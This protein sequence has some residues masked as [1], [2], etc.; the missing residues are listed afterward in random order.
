M[1]SKMHDQFPAGST[2]ERQSPAV[3]PRSVKVSD[4]ADALNPEAA[5]RPYHHGQLR[6]SALL[7]ARQVV[8]QQG[9][10]A[11]SMRELAQQLGVAPSALYRHFADRTA[12]LLE[13]ADQVHAEHLVQLQV[14]QATA[15]DAWTALEDAGR[16]FLRFAQAQ[17]RMFRMMYDDAVIN[18]PRTEA[19]SPS[20]ELT[21]GLL[22][23]LAAQ[24]W[25][26]L[27]PQALRQRL[28]AYWSALFGCAT[29]GSHSLLKP[30]MLIGL[31]PAAVEDAVLAMAMGPRVARG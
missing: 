1:P 2:P 18:A 20:L 11:V 21:Y 4:T 24:A 15:P 8:T 16:H 28:I 14:L 6:S 30:Y 25:P 27:K 31:E 22:L 7:A 19:D 9:H 12:L 29:L 26:A 3:K 23:D 17:P 5:V 13:L 10:V